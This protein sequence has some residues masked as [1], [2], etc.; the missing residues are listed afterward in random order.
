MRIRTFFLPL[1]SLLVSL[2]AGCGPTHNSQASASDELEPVAVTLFTPQLELFM[3]H[4][5]LIRG[6]EVRFLAHLTVLST[7]E[8]VRSGTLVL[9]AVPANG[10]PVTLRADKPARDGLF[11]PEGAFAA[12]GKYRVRL[13]LESPQATETIC[14][15]I[16]WSTLTKPVPDVRQNPI[17]TQTHPMGFRSYSNPS[18]RS[19]CS[20]LKLDVDRSSTDCRF[21]VSFTRHRAL[22][23]SSVRPYRD[24]Y[25]HQP[26]VIYLA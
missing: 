23:L 17:L 13:T 22:L 6:Q 26:R 9:E 7:G 11:V 14:W 20:W 5:R 21:R 10:A 12:A 3:E 24:F 19:V 15:A 8:P 16:L 2:Q 25:D 1:I 18:G 4:P